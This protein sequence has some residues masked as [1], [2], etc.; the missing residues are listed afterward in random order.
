MCCLKAVNNHIKSRL[1]IKKKI[2]KT[3]SFLHANWQKEFVPTLAAIFFK[4]FI[5]S[6]G[7]SGSYILYR[8][9]DFNVMCENVF[10]FDGT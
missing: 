8:S 7:P 6:I 1:R 3:I 10:E 4:G 2:F 9:W 5:I